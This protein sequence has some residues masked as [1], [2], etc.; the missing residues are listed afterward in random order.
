[1]YIYISG[2]GL[3]VGGYRGTEAGHDVVEERWVL[4]L[5]CMYINLY[6][7]IYIHIHTYTYACLHIYIY[8][9]IYAYM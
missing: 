6:I 8:I 7:N 2:F 4:R 9:Y 1:M 5:P 3:R